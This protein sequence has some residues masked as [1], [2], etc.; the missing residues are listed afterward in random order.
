MV[1]VLFTVLA[2]ARWMQYQCLS[3]KLQGN[4]IQKAL[5][6]KLS[7]FFNLKFG[8]VRWLCQSKRIV[9][10]LTILLGELMRLII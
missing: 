4:V 6:G 9:H 10:Q 8:F 3:F 7:V 5:Q 2:Y 1:F